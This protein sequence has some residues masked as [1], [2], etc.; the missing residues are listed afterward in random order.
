MSH[1]LNP[2]IL[3]NNPHNFPPSL[4]PFL[5]PSSDF[6]PLTFPLYDYTTAIIT[7]LLL[8]ASSTLLHYSTYSTIIP[9]I[10]LRYTIP[11]PLPLIGVSCLRVHRLQVIAQSRQELHKVG[12]LIS[13]RGKYRGTCVR[14]PG[15]LLAVYRASSFTVPVAEVL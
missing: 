15:L 7:A 2:Y 14:L 5:T 4:I 6:Y 8:L 3:H 12:I 1:N 13:G 10:L 9:T 11:T